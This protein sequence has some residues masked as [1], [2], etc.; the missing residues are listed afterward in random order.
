MNIKNKIIDYCKDYIDEYNGIKILAIVFFIGSIVWYIASNYFGDLT[1]EYI[2]KIT[3]KTFHKLVKNPFITKVWLVS[4]CNITSII[5]FVKIKNTNILRRVRKQETPE[6]YMQRYKKEKI[7]KFTTFKICLLYLML[8]AVII[9]AIHKIIG[10]TPLLYI[11]KIMQYNAGATL[12]LLVPITAA[13]SSFFAM[14][15]FIEEN[16]FINSKMQKIYNA[17]LFMYISKKLKWLK[18]PL[19]Y[20][21]VLLA[22]CFMIS[23]YS[24]YEA[25][26]LPPW[27]LSNNSM[28]KN[29]I[30]DE[31]RYQFIYGRFEYGMYLDQESYSIKENSDLYKA[32]SE[33]IVIVNTEKNNDIIERQ[34]LYFEIINNEA[35]VTYKERRR[36]IN[37]RNTEAYNML[38]RK[39]FLIG[40]W[41]CYGLPNGNFFPMSENS[42][43]D[44]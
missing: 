3:D 12:F 4:A 24:T 5:L 29:C 43:I 25:R 27:P 41:Q 44:F 23:C 7:T 35:Y 40:Y 39:A 32:W 34:N 15:R 1:G 33:D 37:V 21:S 42:I 6:E 13:Y 14:Q 19:V 36:R 11:N 38:T 16:N 18:F 10:G 8:S 20:P 9:I 17:S 31:H 30:D 2:V 26:Y 28:Y 22:I